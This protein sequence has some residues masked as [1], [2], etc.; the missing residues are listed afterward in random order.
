MRPAAAVRTELWGETIAISKPSKLPGQFVHGWKCNHCDLESWNRNAC[1]SGTQTSPTTIIARWWTLS[2][3]KGGNTFTSRYPTGA[4]AGGALAYGRGTGTEAA[5]NRRTTA[6]WTRWPAID[7]LANHKTL[8]PQSTTDSSPQSP[9]SALNVHHTLPSLHF[10]ASGNVSYKSPWGRGR[11][12]GGAWAGGLV[13]G[14][15]VVVAMVVVVVKALTPSSLYPQDHAPSFTRPRLCS[16]PHSPLP[17]SAGTPCV[18]GGGEAPGK[19]SRKM[20]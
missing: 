10:P 17:V 9:I 1:L 13:V 8:T 20:P 16:A 7:I 12:G 14:V 4:G 11:G 18:H 6:S 5:A 19:R 2:G 3:P 15:V